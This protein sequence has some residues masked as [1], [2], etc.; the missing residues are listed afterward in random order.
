MGASAETE[1][2]SLDGLTGRLRDELARLGAVEGLTTQAGVDQLDRLL[3]TL[4]LKIRP[5]LLHP[6]ELPLF[7]GVQGG[8]N[9]GKSTVFNALA[10]KLL[11]PSVVQA[12]ATKHPLVFVHERWREVLLGD[13]VFEGL[14]LLELEDPKQLLIEPDRTELLYFQFHDDDDL[15]TLALIDSPD[16]D[17]VLETNLIVADHVS[18]LSDLTVFVTTAQKYRDRELISRLRLIAQLKASIILIFNRVDEDIVF[19][20]LVDDLRGIIDF[21]DVDLLT[22][23]TGRSTGACPEDEIRQLLES[24]VLAK[25]RKVETARIKPRILSRACRHFATEV[26]DMTARF[27]P[28]V[29]FKRAL[30]SFLETKCQESTAA[31]RQGFSLALPEES[32][33]I[34]RVLSL[35][36]PGRILRVSQRIEEQRQAMGI[37]GQGIAR[38]TEICRRFL[39]S[40][41]RRGRDSIED[42]SAAREEYAKSRD[43]ADFEQVL[44][45]SESLRLELE[46]FCRARSGSSALARQLLDR[47]FSTEARLR[48]RDELRPAFDTETDQRREGAET[49]LSATETWIDTRP[50]ARRA[51]TWGAISLKIAVGLFLAWLIPPG[52][53]PFSLLNWIWFVL[54]YLLC[55]YGV[56]LSVSLVLSRRRPF[57]SRR[58]EGFQEI[59]R[60]AVAQPIRGEI[61][62]V[63]DE[64]AIQRID[65]LARRLSGH[66]DLK[67]EAVL[68]EEDGEG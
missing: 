5:E 7:V 47:G 28:E 24:T 61:D 36:E 2:D 30:L 13:T 22:L 67:E 62:K 68:F 10:G 17:S 26:L 52:S 45:H 64:D 56:A 37:V 11:S 1:A 8:T 6:A 25:L 59:I 54:G 19:R 21:S 3:T 44:R 14:E 38:W 33:A 58:T 43:D 53:G 12:S 34:T 23:R 15:A 46:A 49:I 65:E 41:A 27:S 50:V 63:L 35:T 32:L 29:E 39:L 31:Y 40:M 51:L 4:R 66:P 16:F 55:A 18:V 57:R 42:T 48:F 9:V 60:S 20:T